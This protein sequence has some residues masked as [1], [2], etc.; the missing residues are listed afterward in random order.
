VLHDHDLA[1]NLFVRLGITKPHPKHS[2]LEN[3]CTEALVGCL[4][5]STLF[6]K[7]FVDLCA[8][9]LNIEAPRDEPQ[10]S[11]QVVPP[12]VELANITASSLTPLKRAQFDIELRFPLPKA[13]RIVIESK[14]DSPV[15]SKQLQEYSDL[16][17]HTKP[18]GYL[19]LLV[20]SAK[21]IPVDA[22]AF[23]KI[24]WEQIYQCAIDGSRNS[25]P[26]AEDDRRSF[27]SA[28]SSASFFTPKV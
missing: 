16:L 1:N 8:A 5:N 20:S 22:R 14:V 10:I 19:L 24:L 6:R 4:Q 28:S 12:K 3:F 25:Y 2:A 13:L 7:Q 23:R 26:K 11:T 18:R 21:R 9:H 27:S 17:E 15:K